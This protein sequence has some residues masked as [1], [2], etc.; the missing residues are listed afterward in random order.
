MVTE[1]SK[2]DIV[3]TGEESDR[4]VR[5]AIKLQDL[6]LEPYVVVVGREPITRTN[7][8]LGGLVTNTIFEGYIRYLTI[9]T[10]DDREYNVGGSNAT[11]SIASES[12]T[13]RNVPSELGGDRLDEDRVSKILD[14]FEAKNNNPVFLISQLRTNLRF[15]GEST[16]ELISARLKR[17]LQ[18]QDVEVKRELV[19]LIA[20]YNTTETIRLLLELFDDDAPEVRTDVALR[21]RGLEKVIKSSPDLYAASVNALIKALH[22]D[23]EEVRI[24][25]AE[26]LGYIQSE[27]AVSHL[28]EI[29]KN[30]QS[31]DARWSAAIALGRISSKSSVPFLVQSTLEDEYYRVRQSCL[32]SLGRLGQEAYAASPNLVGTLGKSL[33]EGPASIKGYAAFALGQLESPSIEYIGQ[34]IETLSPNLSE[35]ETRY[36]YH[37]QNNA[38]LALGRLADWIKAGEVHAIEN[39]LKESLVTEEEREKKSPYYLWF[40]EYAAELASTLELHGL[41]KDY[42]HRLSE[43]ST[44]W[45]KHYYR[46][47]AH[48]ETGEEF[49]EEQDVE[50]AIRYLEQAISDFNKC[51]TIPPE[52]EQGLRFRQ[53]MATARKLLLEGLSEWVDQ[54][55]DNYE[56]TK[57]KFENARK[58]YSAFVTGVSR[59]VEGNKQLTQKEKEFIYG[60]RVVANLGTEFVEIEEALNKTQ[61]PSAKTKLAYVKS[62]IETLIGR[63]KKENVNYLKTLG[64]RILEKITGCLDDL[65]D[66]PVSDVQIIMKALGEIRQTFLGS[67]FPLPARMCPIVG[68]GKARIV[69]RIPGS[70]G[71]SGERQVPYV[72]PS[73]QKLVLVADVYVDERTRSGDQ[74]I[75][76]YQDKGGS[77]QSRIIPVAEGSYPVTIDY[78]VDA[79]SY[80]P[81]PYVMELLFR[82]RDCEQMA[83][84]KELWIQRFDSTSPIILQ[85]ETEPGK[86][87]KKIGIINLAIAQMLFLN[88][89]ERST[90]YLSYFY[91]RDLLEKGLLVFKKTKHRFV[92][93]KIANLV[94]EAKAKEASLVAFPELIAPF[95][96]HDELAALSK[97]LGIYLI[98][99]M[100]H[101][102]DTVSKFWQNTAILFS[103]AG[104]PIIQ[105]KNNPAKIS[106]EGHE[107]VEG[108]RGSNQRKLHKFETSLGRIVTLICSDAIVGKNIEEVEIAIRRE[109][110]PDFI[111]IPSLSQVVQDFFGWSELNIRRLFCSLLFA[112][113]AQFGSSAVFTP[114]KRLLKA[115]EEDRALINRNKV[116]NVRGDG[117]NIDG[118]SVLPPRFE[119]VLVRSVDIEKMRNIRSGKVRDPEYIN[120]GHG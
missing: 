2:I 59:S 84:Q 17:H 4:F 33:I 45:R 108:I 103:P 23:C 85:S 16:K 36:Y 100:E 69:F 44:D 83:F 79:P 88:E 71:G 41:A 1:N 74:L 117:M 87:S 32:L 21:L 27:D 28:V 89:S 68:L 62:E 105:L 38:V 77:T 99:G 18:E 91:Q 65:T 81:I 114:E 22:D 111:A 31:K 19:D 15:F 43:N 60:L 3:F 13:F 112:N 50:R 58:I 96:I 57:A 116:Q 72:F 25:S 10:A 82:G 6:G 24:Y 66:K 94:D 35:L 29:L 73:N 119:G 34:L 101:Q 75:F 90:D 118:I 11:E 95:E 115:I 7:V 20:S 102:R 86:G 93:D 51:G 5:L 63:L 42:Y 46:G 107:K 12:V 40:L 54:V 109:V 106:I 98:I 52:A 110:E 8:T 80:E 97:A 37:I 64:E 76:Y 92:L 9:K 39:K 70:A 30:D 14:D 53:Q 49:A 55:G 104:E 47:I 61:L 113:H 78:G 67:S 26:D 48:Y 56:Q 120:P